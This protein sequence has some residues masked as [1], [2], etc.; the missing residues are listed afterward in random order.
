MRVGILTFSEENN[1]GAMLQAYALQQTVLELGHDVEIIRY[2]KNYNLYRRFKFVYGLM[3][4]R[5]LI[6]LF[7]KIKSP[8]F[9]LQYL[10]EI[11][12][13][14]I[15]MAPRFLPI[16]VAD[17]RYERFRRQYYHRSP[18][19]MTSSDLR[20]N[21]KRYDAIIV[22]SDQVWNGEYTVGRGHGLVYFLDFAT[23]LLLRRISYAASAGSRAQCEN[24]PLHINHLLNQFAFLSVRD[25][26]TGEMVANWCGRSDYS[27]VCD[28]TY[29]HSFDEFSAELPP[30]YPTRYILAYSVPASILSS[31]REAL[32]IIKQKMKIP[33]VAIIATAH[34]DVEW[35][36]ADIKIRTA[37]PVDFVNLFRHA[38]YILTDSFHGTI[39]AIKNRVPFSTCVD[40]KGF[41]APRIIDMLERFGLADRIVHDVDSARSIDTVIDDRLLDD[42][43]ALIAKDANISLSFLRNALS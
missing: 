4:Q 6:T 5:G 29:L 23:E 15:S 28:P 26:L 11:Y 31:A 10:R 32:K 20:E 41:S 12:W 22:G 17:Y 3:K 9:S 8:C 2:T 40:P 27:V 42:A 21:T 7:N 33:V 34:T 19:C 37:S 16:P 43:F 30:K 25:N 18:I 14:F 1:F 35:V 24:M 36:N 39:L 13:V 38:S